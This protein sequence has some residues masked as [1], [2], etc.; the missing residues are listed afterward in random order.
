MPA[1]L[2]LS[3]YLVSRF[4]IK[5]THLKEPI[6]L[7]CELTKTFYTTP[8]KPGIGHFYNN[9]RGKVGKQS[10]QN[11]L[12]FT[13]KIQEDWTL[14]LKFDDALIMLLKKTFISFD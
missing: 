9:A 8:R 2:L 1:F 5:N 6:Y 11:Y 4:V 13:D 14:Q 10:L 3:K 12:A 7:L